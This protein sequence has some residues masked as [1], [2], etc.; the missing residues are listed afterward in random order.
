MSRRHIEQL[1]AGVETK[2]VLKKERRS[3][4]KR[5]SADHACVN[6]TRQQELQADELLE[7]VSWFREDKRVE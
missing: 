3:G 5:G 7:E 6:G 2:K 1:T 4:M